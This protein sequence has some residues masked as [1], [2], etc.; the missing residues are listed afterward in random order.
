MEAYERT[1]AEIVVAPEKVE[2]AQA[3]SPIY[4]RDLLGQQSML[5]ENIDR[6]VLQQLGE[7]RVPS[8]SDLF[9]AKMEKGLGEMK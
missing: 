7:V 2:K 4:S 8:I 3:L 1:F 6:E 5:F 9:I